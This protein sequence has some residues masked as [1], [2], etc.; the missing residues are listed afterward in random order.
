MF[1]DF[2]VIWDVVVDVADCGVLVVNRDADRDVVLGDVVADEDSGDAV[3]DADVD[4]V[5][6]VVNRADV[7]ASS[8][9]VGDV[10]VADAVRGV[11]VVSRDG[12]VSPRAP[13]VDALVSS[14]LTQHI[15]VLQ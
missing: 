6:V 11:F 8:D 14:A 9:W 10:A 4:W 12:V 13:V 15:S 5:V 3:S 1:C 7:F 2:D